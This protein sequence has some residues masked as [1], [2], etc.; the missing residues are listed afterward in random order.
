M[1]LD[2]QHGVAKIDQAVQHVKQLAH[3]VEMQSRRWL[4]QDVQRAAGLAFG[5]FA[6]QFDALGFAAGK[7]RRGLPQRYV[8]ESHVHQRRKLLLNL[9]NVFQ[10]FKRLG[11]RQVQYV[12]DRMSLVA[13]GERL[14]IVAATAAHFAHHINIGKKIHFDA[15]QAVALASFAAPAFHVE[16]EAARA[17]AALARLREHGKQVADG[18]K[19]SGVGR[20]VRTRRA[21]NR[22]LIDLNDLVDV[23]GAEDLPMRGGRFRGTIEL[24]RQRAIQNIVHQ[25]GFAGAG[26]PGD[27][28]EQ[29]QRK[30]DVNLLEIVRCGSQ[31]LNGF[32]VLAAP[33]FRHRNFRRAPQ[34]LPGQRL[35]RGFDLFR[36]ALRNQI[37]AGV[38][39][40]RAEIH[41]KIRPANGV[42][43]MLDHQHR[44]AQV[45]KVFERA[46]QPR[47][48]ARVQPDARLIEHVEHA[49]Q[50]RA[51]LRSQANPLCFAAG[52]RSRRALQAQVAQAHGE[53]KVDALRD[54]F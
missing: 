30:G 10:E 19:H 14:G 42:F 9:G 52:E 53:K 29:A 39:R 17:V 15:P 11:A 24:L 41:H 13:H 37:A 47:I 45:A 46:E 33:F 54:F 8:A 5:K 32:A 51:N 49:A 28:R 31:D 23:F 22:R 43:V 48:V 35:S 50:S 4:I 20:R 2:D 7:R 3:V 27:H 25:R 6:R 1:V 40:A 16:A 18:R 21:A 38:P 36:L 34:V 26:N 12:A 44:V